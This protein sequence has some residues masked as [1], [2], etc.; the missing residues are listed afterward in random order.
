MAA[1]TD[2][3]DDAA[4]PRPGNARPRRAGAALDPRARLRHPGGPPATATRPRPPREGARPIAARR[5]RVTAAPPVGGGSIAPPVRGDATAPP[6]RGD[7][8]VP[9]IRGGDVAP[10]V[11]PPLPRRR[12]DRRGRLARW[13]PAAGLLAIMA[14]LAVAADVAV[15]HLTDRLDGAAAMLG[16]GAMLAI[17]ALLMAIPF[18][19][20]I[21]VVV[22]LLILNGPGVMPYVWIATL[23]GLVLSYGVGRAIP[24]GALAALL[25]RLRQRRAAAAVGALMSRPP[26]RRLA[27][28]R[29]LLPRRLAPLAGAGR[30]VVLAILV[31]LPGAS[32]IGGGGG[33]ALMAGY[34]RLFAPRAV[35]LT[36][37]I[38]T[39]PVPLAIWLGGPALL[40]LLGIEPP[41]AG[42]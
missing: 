26:E 35:I 3:G 2:G 20:G 28:L 5:P 31:N 7:A 14:G 11:R 8:A 24:P 39:A 4:P 21:A 32:L 1:A 15:V 27:F 33:L 25:G 29:G 6:V 22:P 18:V 30:Y 9:P 16:V 12:A 17:Y 19:P 13:A 40:A 10:P 41:P 37:A 34:T 36:L 38:A 23:G 42:Q